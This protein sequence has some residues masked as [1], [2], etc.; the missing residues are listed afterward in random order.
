MHT[1]SAA[2]AKDV[3]EMLDWADCM[4]CLLFFPP[5]V[6]LSLVLPAI[7]VGFEFVATVV[8]CDY[9]DDDDLGVELVV[10]RILID[11]LDEQV[12]CLWMELTVAYVNAN[13]N[14]YETQCVEMKSTDW[15][16]RRYDAC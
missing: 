4:C 1:L 9:D 13:W 6:V 11:A 15:K 2:L 10:W 16:K 8:D 7:L 3:Y 5:L 12:D 14:R